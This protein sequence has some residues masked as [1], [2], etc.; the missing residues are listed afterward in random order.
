M[1]IAIIKLGN[2]PGSRPWYLA[3]GEKLPFLQTLPVASLFTW[4]LSKIIFNCTIEIC[5]M[6]GEGEHEVVVFCTWHRSPFY[7]KC[8]V[9]WQIGGGGGWWRQPLKGHQPI[10]WPFFPETC[11]KMKFWPRDRPSRDRNQDEYHGIKEVFLGNIFYQRK[12]LWPGSPNRSN[13]LLSHYNTDDRLSVISP[14]HQ[15]E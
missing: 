11:M 6:K 10:I 13:F 14:W 4:S 9:Q 8:Q 15:G 3:L 5:N 7:N 2:R 1:F 12:N